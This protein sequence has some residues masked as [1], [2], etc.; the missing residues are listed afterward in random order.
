VL[1]VTACG[2]NGDDH[3]SVEDA[4]RSLCESDSDCLPESC[5]NDTSA[6]NV[7]QLILNKKRDE[8]DAL[9]TRCESLTERA[10]LML[11][12]LSA[13]PFVVAE[14]GEC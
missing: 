11:R 7:E 13:D 12:R 1:A 14:A 9:H 8:L 3:V 6:F 10:A 5:S 4:A 2:D